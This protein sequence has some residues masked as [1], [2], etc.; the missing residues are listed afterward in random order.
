MQ[1]SFN[2]FGGQAEHWAPLVKRADELGFDAVWVS[3]HLIT[4][5][6]YSSRYPYDPSGKA[7][8]SPDTPLLDPLLTIA[9]LAAVTERIK[10]GT[11][12]YILPLRNPFVTAR[13]V[14]T[15]QYYS[16]GR[17]L[18]GVGAGWLGEEFEAVGENFDQRGKRMDEI[19]EVLK[20]LWTGEPVSFKGEF[21]E[22]HEVQFSPTPDPIPIIFGGDT[23][24][25][26]R[27]AAR[28]GDG[29]YGPNCTMEETLATVKKL[30][31][32]REEAGRA[33]KPF[34]FW[35]RC[36][37]KPTLDNVKRYQ[38]AGLDSLTLSPWPREAVTLDQRIE[39]LERLAEDVVSKV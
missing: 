31:E 4:P 22:F 21:F 27:R 5:M 37:G 12:V 13:A 20:T 18:F 26:L 1:F 11:G 10:L 25:A 14:A 3:D 8:Y 7:P 38:E 2:L 23:K 33:D 34:Q 35:S 6:D 17:V 36:Y 24:S 16:K 9:H 15:A 30:N 29:W 39:A 19:L 28:V 32:L